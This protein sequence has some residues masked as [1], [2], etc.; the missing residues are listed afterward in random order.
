MGLPE[1]VQSG[2]LRVGILAC[3]RLRGLACQFRAGAGGSKESWPASIKNQ[4]TVSC[5]LGVNVIETTKQTG[6]APSSNGPKM[7]EKRFLQ[8]KKIAA[9]IDTLTSRGDFGTGQLW[10]TCRLQARLGASRGCSS[11]LSRVLQGS[12]RNIPREL[13]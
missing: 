7:H 8:R 12:G 6:E 10:L 5:L 3:S 1:G 9:R 11:G 2:P 13:L 4:G